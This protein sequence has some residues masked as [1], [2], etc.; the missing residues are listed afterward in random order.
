[1]PQ[2]LGNDW[3]DDDLVGNGLLQESKSLLEPMFTKIID[4]IWHQ[5]ASIVKPIL[6]LGKVTAIIKTWI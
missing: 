1:M 2:D 5:R 3:I 6:P 4:A